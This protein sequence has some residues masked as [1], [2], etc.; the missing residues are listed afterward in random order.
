ML[1]SLNPTPPP[2]TGGG[3]PEKSNY[4]WVLYGK[5]LKKQID[6]P[7]GFRWEMRF[8]CQNMSKTGFQMLRVAMHKSLAQSCIRNRKQYMKI[9]SV[10]FFIF[11]PYF[12][13]WHAISISQEIEQK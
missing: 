12:V 13:K 7:P 2:G 11:S 8:C 10:Q 3:G 9:L 4:M 1:G 6:S 5:L